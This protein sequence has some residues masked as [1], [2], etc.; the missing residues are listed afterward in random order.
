MHRQNASFRRLAR[1]PFGE[2]LNAA[3]RD[4]ALLVY[5]DAPANRKGHPNENLVRE[6]MELFTLGVGHYSENDVQEVA[7]AL[8]GWTVTDGVF[9]EVPARH[10]GGSKTILGKTGNWNGSDVVRIILEQPATAHRLAWRICDLLLGEGAID[11]ESMRELGDSLWAHVRFS[12][13]NN[14]WRLR[15]RTRIGP[16][17]ACAGCPFPLARRLPIRITQPSR[18]RASSCRA[19]A[20]RR[21]R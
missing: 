1:A 9:H 13:S 14:V 21:R 7:R 8:T 3:L 6:M 5:L 15:P 18:A 11:P 2:L 17:S 12:L 16:P 20:W 4:P 10:D 19:T